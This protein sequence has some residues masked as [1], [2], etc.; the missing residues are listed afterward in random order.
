MTLRAATLPGGLAAVVADVPAPAH[1]PLLYVHGMFGGAWMLEGLMRRLA[2]RGRPGTALD[3]R[4]HGASPPVAALGRVS[5]LDYVDDALS[6]ARALGRPIVVG[7][8]MGGLIAL[9]LAEA[10]A[11]AAAV[12]LCAAPPRGISVLSPSLLP[13]QVKHLPALL[14]SRPLV[15]ARGDADAIMFNHV[16]PAERDALFARLVPES[17]RAGR[18]ISF[19]RIAVD[20]RRVRCPVLSV[21]ALDDRFLPPRIARAI[22]A[23][24]HAD[25]IELQGHGHLLIAEPG[26]ERVADEIERWIAAVIPGA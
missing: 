1:P 25:L 6:A 9:K 7:H 19:G 8:S 3:L 15:A 14:G 17:G 22:A 21:G 4:G 2:A 12:L 16:P 26:W 13:R 20:P 23:R 10:D 5:V 24:Y 18:E 11:V